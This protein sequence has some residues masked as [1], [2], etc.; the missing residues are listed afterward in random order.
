VST[1]FGCFM[2]RQYFL[3]GLLFALGASMACKERD[4]SPVVVHVLRDALAPFAKALSQCDL[5]F[6]LTKP[7]VS[8]G[9][10]VI[11]GTNAGSSS[12]SLLV[13]RLADKTVGD[14]V[15]LNSPSDLPESV[16]NH[17]GKQQ[18][19]CGGAAAYI[20]D[21]VSGESREAS[22]MYLQYLTAHCE[23]SQTP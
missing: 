10:G 20:P 15:I 16:R 14:L 12:F 17:A 18:L 19:I 7:H 23:C 9:R 22:E 3:F 13:K 6:G 11:V 5:Q 1:P 21:W 4:N 8:S 2:M